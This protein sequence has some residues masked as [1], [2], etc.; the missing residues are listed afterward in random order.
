MASGGLFDYTD[1]VAERQTPAGLFVFRE[2]LLPAKYESNIQK[3]FDSVIVFVPSFPGPSHIV[4]LEPE[5]DSVSQNMT[6]PGARS[7]AILRDGTVQINICRE[8]PE[9]RR[10]RIRPQ[11]QVSKPHCANR[12]K[13]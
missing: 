11:K 8:R 9:I 3:E 13:S 4:R 12:M 7:D 10:V 2:R 1:A 6:V 5:S